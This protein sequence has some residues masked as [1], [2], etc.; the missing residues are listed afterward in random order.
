MFGNRT[1]DAQL[2]PNDSTWAPIMTHAVNCLHITV[3]SWVMPCHS[4][5][6]NDPYSFIHYR[7]YI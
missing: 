3:E 5:S 4:H 7:L 1:Q 6:T 2:G